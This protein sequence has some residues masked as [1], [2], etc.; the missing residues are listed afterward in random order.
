MENQPNK[1]PLCDQYSIQKEPKYGDYF[2]FECPGC[3]KIKLSG[4]LKATFV[5]NRVLDDSLVA[6][7]RHY[8][9]KNRFDGVLYESDVE[10]IQKEF[11]LP[12]PKE[13]LDRLIEYLGDSG[14]IGIEILVDPDVLPR[15]IGAKTP[16]NA[17]FIADAAVTEGLLEGFLL[18]SYTRNGEKAEPK[19]MRLTMKGWEYYQEL[20]TRKT[21]D[22]HKA[23]MAMPFKWPDHVDIGFKPENLFDQ[24]RVAI[25]QKTFFDLHRVD[26][27]PRS[28]IIDDHLRVDIRNARFVISDLTGCNRGAY[29]EAGYAEGLGKKVI[30]TCEESYFGS[31]DRGTHFDTNHCKTVKWNQDNLQQ[32]LDDLLAIIQ[33][34]FPDA[35]RAL[36]G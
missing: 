14:D 20:K 19:H 12:T 7:V 4:T 34:E 21:V 32:A 17:L 28:G 8:V 1:C 3:G 29:W 6:K 11:Y 22:T 18:R 27:Q 2:S 15:I 24:F 31:S 30:Y 16:P 5:N 25:S 23:F 36:E 26:T 33:F 13:Q 35:C 9:Y 10:R